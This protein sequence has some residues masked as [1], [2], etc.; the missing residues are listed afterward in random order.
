MHSPAP[1]APEIHRY[2]PSAG[3]EINNSS[4]AAENAPR[5]EHRR[6]RQP[7]AREEPAAVAT[8]APPPVQPIAK[9]TITLADGPSKQR[10]QR[11]LDNTGAKL[12]K[13]DRNSLGADSAIT[14]DQATNLLEAGRRAA[15]EDDYVAAAGFAEK[16][17]ALAAKLGSGSP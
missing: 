9:P 7:P 14:Y 11:L 15:N 1:A 5:V 17:A 6:L 10:A 12:A 13:V 8:P 3:E 4:P 16:A 2:P